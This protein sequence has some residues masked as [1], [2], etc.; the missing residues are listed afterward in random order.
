MPRFK[1]TVEYDGTSYYGWQRQEGRPT[2]QLAL[3]NALRR[4]TQSDV[5]VFAAGRTDTGVHGLGQVVHVDLAEKW[6]AEAVFKAV[7]ACLRMAN[8]PVSIL[9]VEAVGDDFDARFSAN[10]RHYRYIIINRTSQ[11]TIERNMAWWVSRS[12][13]AEAMHEAARLLVGHHDFT[14]FRSSH[15]QAKS[16]VKT[17]ERLD[18]KRENDR[19]IIEAS[20][21][22]FLHNQIRSFVGSLKLV[23]DG[24]WQASDLK[25]ALD[26]RDRTR[27]GPV[28]PPQGLFLV[29][30][31]Y[32]DAE[33][34]SSPK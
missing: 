25:A 6:T 5:T 31:D 32:P 7:N 14:T 26:A 30:V 34:G 33:A 17:L 28:A 3:E 2:V 1:L 21:R 24:M 8:D 16:P 11:L 27:C 9:E 4:F 29:R 12:L 23:G 19:I 10:K 22:S 15:C 13:D 20:A 18:V